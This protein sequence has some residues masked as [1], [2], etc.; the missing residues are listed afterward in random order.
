MLYY[1]CIVHP[2]TR[3]AL[4]MRYSLMIVIAM[5]ASLSPIAYANDARC[6]APPNPSNVG[7]VYYDLE[8]TSELTDDAKNSM[9]ACFNALASQCKGEA[10]TIECRAPI[11][12]PKT[13]SHNATITAQRHLSNMTNVSIDA[14]NHSIHQEIEPA[15]TLVLLGNTAIVNL[16]CA[17]KHRRLTKPVITPNPAATTSTFSSLFNQITG[18]KE[19]HDS[20]RQ[21]A[22]I[23]SS[24]TKTPETSRFNRMTKTSDNVIFDHNKLMISRSYYTNNVLTVVDLRQLFRD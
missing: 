21:D 9:N 19:H 23:D 17:E 14:T 6:S 18:R 4:C 3:K 2:S 7:E 11:R 20:T 24:K 16:A 13:Q 10:R 12:A 22:T 8:N 1:H 5:L 15:E